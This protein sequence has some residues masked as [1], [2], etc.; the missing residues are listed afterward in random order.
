[1]ACLHRYIEIIPQPER[2]S[3]HTAHPEKVWMR[4]SLEHGVTCSLSGCSCSVADLALDEHPFLLEFV[5]TLEH[6][7]VPALGNYTAIGFSQALKA[8]VHMPQGG[9]HRMNQGSV[10]NPAPHSLHDAMMLLHD[11]VH[12]LNYVEYVYYHKKAGLVLL[13]QT[14][15]C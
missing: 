10:G 11:L 5:V 15:K 13:S 1:M 14:T 3:P 4:E 12:S 7:A 8:C 6:F 9:S 2:V